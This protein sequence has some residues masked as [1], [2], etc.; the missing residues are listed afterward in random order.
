MEFP[1]WR[2]IKKI[3]INNTS[4]YGICLWNINYLLVGCIDTRIKIIDLNSETIIMDLIGHNQEIIDIKKIY[5]SKFSECF[6]SKGGG[7]DKI[8]LWRKKK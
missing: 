1:Y 5:H 4:I 3:I 6:I 2:I 7:Y 8:I